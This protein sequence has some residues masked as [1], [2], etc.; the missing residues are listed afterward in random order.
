ML[1]AHQFIIA[2]LATL[3]VMPQARPCPVILFKDIQISSP[4]P[5]NTLCPGTNVS[6]TLLCSAGLIR[7]MATR[8]QLRVDLLDV[9]CSDHNFTVRWNAVLIAS[10]Y[11]LC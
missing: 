4:I 3:S 10:I 2:Y 9:K 5:F 8:H 7:D 1:S 11:I 6:C